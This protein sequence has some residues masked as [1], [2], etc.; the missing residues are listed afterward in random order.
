MGKGKS[1]KIV[2]PDGDPLNPIK[3][4]MSSWLG[5]AFRIKRECLPF[6]KNIPELKQCGVY[7]LYGEVRNTSGQM[8]RK[9]YIGQGVLRQNGEGV[10]WRI[11]EHDTPSETFW[12]DAVAF[13]DAKNVWGKT[14]ISYLENRFTN[15]VIEAKKGAFLF[16]IAN[17]NNPNPGR[18]TESMQWELDEYI[19]GAEIILQVLGYDFFR[20]EDAPASGELPFEKSAQQS[21]QAT[22]SGTTEKPSGH[23]DS[24]V[25]FPFK[26]GRVMAYAFREAL[27]QGLLNND[28]AFL[29]SKDA[30]KLFKTRGYKVIVP[31]ETQPLPVHGVSRYSKEPVLLGN[32]K[33]WITTQVYKEGLEPLLMYLEQNGMSKDDVIVVCKGEKMEV[34]HA[35]DTTYEFHSFR[36]YLQKTMCKHSAVSYA[37]SFKDLEQI[38]L[39]AKII[40]APLSSDTSS[41]EIEAI[42]GFISSNK[43]FREYNKTKHHSRSAAWRKFEDYLQAL[44]E[45]QGE[46][47]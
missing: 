25:V 33:Y 40:S 4:E 36:D 28:L 7:F 17:G 39:N 35:P 21:G 1:I 22:A 10:F 26:I 34:K 32:K 47:K 46:V 8:C 23:D 3:V 6:A 13:V 27:S 12:T 41:N 30:C 14:E 5:F 20:K 43:T 9:I 37:S 42:R 2:V 44:A 19:E 11:K 15:S 31:S 38:L 16:E 45:S 24:N 18:V 29:E